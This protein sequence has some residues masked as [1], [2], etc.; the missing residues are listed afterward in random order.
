ME[1]KIGNHCSILLLDPGDQGAGISAQELT[2]LRQW[3]WHGKGAE[4]IG[5]PRCVECTGA[6]HVLNV[7]L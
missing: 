4:I 7:S 6:A 1:K 2:R 3:S 5:F